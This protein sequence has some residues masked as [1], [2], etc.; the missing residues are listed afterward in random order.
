MYVESAAPF[1]KIWAKMIDLIALKNYPISMLDRENGLFISQKIT[2]PY[3][4]EPTDGQSNDTSA[5]IILPR[6][7]Y[8]YFRNRTVDIQ[9]VIY[10]D[11]ISMVFNIR[12]RSNG[13]TGSFVNVNIPEVSVKG[14]YYNQREVKAGDTTVTKIPVSVHR[15]YWRAARS[16]GKLEK[17]IIEAIK[18]GKTSVYAK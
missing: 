3:A 11:T 9:K 12:I 1:E 6:L 16:T 15:D 8:Q 13:S 2:L 7:R 18:D 5:Y 14:G 10:P 17:M 4:I